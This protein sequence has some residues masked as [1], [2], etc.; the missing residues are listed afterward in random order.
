MPAQLG[1]F[2]IGGQIPQADRVIGAAGCQAVAVWAEGHFVDVAAVPQDPEQLEG[3][4]IPEACRAV[5]GSR[6]KKSAISAER[7]RIDPVGM[8]MQDLDRLLFRYVPDAHSQVIA[9]GGDAA[10]G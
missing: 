9:R 4:A 1:D 6:S 8:P 2:L 5:C 10:A 3:G 7:D